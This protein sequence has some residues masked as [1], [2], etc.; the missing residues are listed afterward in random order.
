M[1]EEVQR[2]VIVMKNFD[3]EK[4]F[5]PGND[6]VIAEGVEYGTVLTVILLWCCNN[7]SDSA[8]SLKI[9]N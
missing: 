3:F 6:I 9:T 7:V 4:R 8:G 1:S 2:V 5:L